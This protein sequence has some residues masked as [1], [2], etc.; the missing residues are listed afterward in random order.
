MSST[1]I[2]IKPNNHRVHPCAN[3]RKLALVQAIISKNESKNIFIT[4]AGDTKELE[5]NISFDNVKIFTDKTLIQENKEKCDLLIS[6]DLPAKAIIYTAR[7]GFT[8][9]HAVIILEK[10]EQHLLYPIETL[11]G[12]VIKQEIIEGYEEPK[13]E[14]KEPVM[15]KLTKEQI[16]EIAK[17]RYEEQTSEPKEKTYDNDKKFEKREKFNKFDK[18]DDKKKSF[19]KDRKPAKKGRTI[20]IKALKKKDSE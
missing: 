8:T 12:R 7:L 16:T 6:F 17:K 9:S 10:D 4:T 20:A 3:D 2:S 18:K 11:M 14:R 15:K 5:E 1:S 13:E 19:S